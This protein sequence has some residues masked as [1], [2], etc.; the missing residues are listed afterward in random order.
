MVALRIEFPEANRAALVPFEL[1]DEPTGKQLLL[2]AEYS[3]ISAGTEGA[4]FTGLELGVI[5]AALVL[6][7]YGLT[8]FAVSSAFG[9]PEANAVVGRGLKIIG[10]KKR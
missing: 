7:P 8:Y 3:V 2:Q 6:V 9:L 5:A 4:T 1:A 10:L